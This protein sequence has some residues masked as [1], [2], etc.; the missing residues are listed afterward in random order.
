MLDIKD[1]G[2]IC[3]LANKLF[4]ESL[5][6]DSQNHWDLT[7]EEIKISAIS[8]VEYFLAHPDMRASDSHVEWMRFKISEGWVYGSI[9]DD[10]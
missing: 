10:M 7:D 8:G 2:Q 4:C 1:V 3:H 5:G 6:D 9:K